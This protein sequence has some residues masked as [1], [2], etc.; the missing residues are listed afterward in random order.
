MSIAAIAKPNKSWRCQCSSWLPPA[1]FY[2][3]TADAMGA[4]L[5][6]YPD[7]SVTNS[8]ESVSSPPQRSSLTSVGSPPTITA[9]VS[10]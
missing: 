3:G 7:G 6:I 4:A 9:S 10:R 8:R 1:V 2:Q 5:Y